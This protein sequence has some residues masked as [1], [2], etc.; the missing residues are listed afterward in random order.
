MTE[1]VSQ[2]LL[3]LAV[4]MITVFAILG[5]VVLTG[6][7]LIRLTNRLATEDAIPAKTT[8]SDSISSHLPS[9]SIETKKV[10]AIIATVATVTNGQGRIVK[11]EKIV[12]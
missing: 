3:L 8:S 5:I 6:Q 12:Q 7:V 9:T 2:T 10:A 4:G 1:S 11:I